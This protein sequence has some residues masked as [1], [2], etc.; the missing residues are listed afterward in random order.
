MKLVS[1]QSERG[2]EMPKAGGGSPWGH[3]FCNWKA[4]ARDHVNGR[5]EGRRVKNEGKSELF[6]E[7]HTTEKKMKVSTSFFKPTSLLCYALY[8]VHFCPL[9]KLFLSTK[10]KIK[11]METLRLSWPSFLSI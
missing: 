5:W 11:M 8:L 4:L 2:T 10:N 7:E 1:Y 9:K 3:F 6:S